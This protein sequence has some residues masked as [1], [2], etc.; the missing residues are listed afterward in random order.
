[1]TP[2]AA[3]QR[4]ARERRT[5]AARRFKPRKVE[6]L[7][8]AEAPPGTLERYFYFPEVTEHDSLF[9][10]VA[11]AIL[12][13]EPTRANKAELLGQLRDRGV[14]LIDLKRDPVDGTPLADGVPGLLR[15]VKRL[16]PEKIILIKATVHDAAY[17]PLVGAGLPV[18]PE[19]V[20]FPGSGQQTRFE[21]IFARALRHRP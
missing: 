14:F 2:S 16:D 12:K 1:M 8:V 19:R 6:L 18:A 7:L 5:R 15:R 4:K 3:T 11:R 10:Y 20:P 13:I 21:E 9:R 17:L